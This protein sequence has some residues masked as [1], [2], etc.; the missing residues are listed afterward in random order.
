[1]L[2]TF[3]RIES[4]AALRTYEAAVQIREAPEPEPTGG[5]GGWVAVG[6]VLTALAA[7]WIAVVSGLLALVIAG[8]A[9]CLFASLLS[10]AALRDGRD[11]RASRRAQAPSKSKPRSG[12][13]RMARKVS[14]SAAAMAS[15]VPPR[16]TTA[17]SRTTSAPAS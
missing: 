10:A 2:S 12:A 14:P 6:A 1:M 16:S 17:T 15:A 13:V 11:R 4:A 8:V 3:N 5:H 9:G 7:M